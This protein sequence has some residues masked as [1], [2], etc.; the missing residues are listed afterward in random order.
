MELEK[1]LCRTSPSVRPAAIDGLLIEGF[2]KKRWSALED[3]FR[4][5]LF[6]AA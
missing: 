3:D 5:F 1:V 6:D 4:T 2:R